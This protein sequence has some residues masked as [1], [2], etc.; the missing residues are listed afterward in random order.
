MKL[1]NSIY[2]LPLLFLFS[3]SNPQIHNVDAPGF[4]KAMDSL[5]NEQLVDVRTPEEFGESW[6]PGAENM[7]WEGQSF[8]L[9]T[10]GLDKE[11]PV[12][13]YCRSGNR[14]AKAASWF[15]EH[16]FKEVYNLEGGISDWEAKQFI[17]EHAPKQPEPES[18]VLYTPGTF[19]TMIDT[20]AFVLVDFGATWCGP[21]KMLAPS[22]E[23]I[24]QEHPE[25]HVVKMDADRDRPVTDSM[26]IQSLP[27]LLLYKKGK[28]AWKQVGLVGKEVIVA[29]IE[30]A[31]D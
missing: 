5:N 24:E 30:K 7:N 25:L 14:S 8:E 23:A 31:R 9:M 13:V 20:S 10:I 19:K 3:C 4:A 11:R 29:E 27:T 1:S 21:C 12:M 26:G 15:L 28:L 17:V 18:I 6:I 2:I 22:I 16:G